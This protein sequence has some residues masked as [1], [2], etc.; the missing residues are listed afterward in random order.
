MPASPPDTSVTSKSPDAPD[1]SVRTVQVGIDLVRTGVV[2]ASITAHGSRYLERMYNEQELV[3]CG[4]DGRRGVFDVGGL[5]E[6]FAAKEVTVKDVRPGG[7]D[8]RNGQEQ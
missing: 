1:A 7:P 3:D 5:A 2:Q 6:R 4:A 8:C